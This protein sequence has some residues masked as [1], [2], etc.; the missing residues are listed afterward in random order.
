M[1][2]F[3]CYRWRNTAIYQSRII[4]QA[5]FIY[6]PLD[7]AFEKQIKSTKEEGQKEVEALEILKLRKN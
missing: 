6:Y 7:K 1:I 5:D 3:E 2:K 4:E